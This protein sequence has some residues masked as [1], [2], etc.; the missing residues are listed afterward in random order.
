[1]S[2]SILLIT[3][4]V[5]E[6]V[7]QYMMIRISFIFNL[8]STVSLALEPSLAS[9]LTL[10][11]QPHLYMLLN[12]VKINTLCIERLSYAYIFSSERDCEV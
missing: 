11:V 12:A 9:Y 8:C 6:A 7:A 1:M 10:Y 2:K 5:S 4:N 3:L